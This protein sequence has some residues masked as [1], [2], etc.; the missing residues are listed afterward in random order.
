MDRGLIF[1]E[2]KS[3]VEHVLGEDLP[4]MDGTTDLVNDLGVDS[5]TA[6]EI[7]VA[8]EQ[9]MGVEID[10]TQVA[11]LNTVDQVVDLILKG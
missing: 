10:P 11:S 1:Q 9:Q 2:L 5:F 4:H 8:V 7:L 6:T 3:I